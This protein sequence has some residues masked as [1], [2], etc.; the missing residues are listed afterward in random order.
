MR[1]TKAT[2]VS[3]LRTSDIARHLVIPDGIESTEWPSVRATLSAL[4]I[5]FDLWQ[6]G[7][8]K[9]ILGKRSDGLYACDPAVLSIP[10]QIGKTYLVGW[11]VF[12]L[13]IIKPGLRVIWTAH[14]KSLALETFRELSGMARM[15]K[16]RGHVEPKGIYAGGGPSGFE[17]N[18][19]N[20]SR[21]VFGARESGFG[22][23]FTKIDVLVFDEAQILSENA[24]DSMVPATNH[25]ENPLILHMGTPPKPKDVSESFLRL[26][27]EALEGIDGIFYVEFSAD[28]DA[29]LN[30]PKV[31]E[32]VNPGFPDR[33][34]IAAYRR[35]RKMLSEASFRREALGIWDDMSSARAIYSG[36]KWSSLVNHAPPASDARPNA[37]AVDMWFDRT[38][39]V[40]GCWLEDV[41]VGGE[42]VTEAHV[43]MLAI[44][45]VTDSSLV[46]DW[47]CK[48]AKRRMPVVIDAAGPGAALIPG[49]RAQRVNVIAANGQDV[50][51]ACGLMFDMVSKGRVFHGNHEQ[52]NEAMQSVQRRPIGSAGL[53][54]YDRTDPD[55]P[56][57]SAVSATMALYGAFQNKRPSSGGRSPSSG[58]G[59]EIW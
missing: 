57:S 32:S 5:G 11:I 16:M 8:A 49:L 43:E 9:V 26:R 17:I 53:W 45:D 41:E 58:R 44:S 31:Y 24:V 22:R 4:G 46:I 54:G 30:D 50:G 38:V 2:R 13:C 40:A 12:A 56:I 52:L 34:K 47:I 55:I 25:S 33:T 6:Q 10:R 27:E 37:M 21:I 51:R 20:G 3:T 28:E 35:M 14:R 59:G 7:I 19:R 23:G 36:S 48:R 15:A 42:K 18:F 1:A 29:D 39:T